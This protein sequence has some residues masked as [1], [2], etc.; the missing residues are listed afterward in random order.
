MGHRRPARVCGVRPHS[1][2]NSLRAYL[3]LAG[4]RAI[5][6]PIFKEPF[7][8]HRSVMNLYERWDRRTRRYI[9]LCAA[10]GIDACFC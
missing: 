7:S 5:E 10:G 2:P 3:S 1:A 4:L 8:R 9:P 6:K